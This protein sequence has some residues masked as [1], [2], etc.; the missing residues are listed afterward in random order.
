MIK[1][2][3]QQSSRTSLQYWKTS[4]NRWISDIQGALTVGVIVDYL[5]LWNTLHDVLLQPGVSDSHFWRFATSGQTVKLAYE[6]FFKTWALAKCHFFTWL[7]AHN[8]FWTANHL[9]RRG[10]DHPEECLLCGREEETID[11]L[12]ISCVF[13][14]EFWFKLL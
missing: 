6:G 2:I 12:M 8:K 11:H 4:P 1:I 7:V 13:A 14:R 5:H 10:M 3:K 9:A